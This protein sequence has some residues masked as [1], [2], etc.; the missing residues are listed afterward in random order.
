MVFSTKSRIALCTFFLFSFA[1][2][3]FLG[4]GKGKQAKTEQTEEF[5]IVATTGIIADAVENIVGDKAEVRALMG[6]GVDPHLYKAS[7]GDVSRLAEADIIVY[8]GL[9][10]EGKM[11]EILDKMS[12]RKTVIAAGE[13]LPDSLLVSPTEYA[14]QH[15]PHIWFDLSLWAK[16]VDKLGQ[17]LA[18]EKPEYK[19]EILAN[20]KEY[21]G[22]IEALHSRILLDIAGIPKRQRVLITAHDAFGYFGRA[23]EIEVRGLQGISTVSEY[24]LRDVSELVD[25][26]AD[27]EIKAIFV[28]SSVPKRS[29]EAVQKGVEGKG[30]EVAIGGELYSDALGEKGSEAE[31]YLGMVK[32][33]VNTIVQA[34]K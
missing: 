31:T 7:E 26:I 24:G 3:L 2:I 34:L 10:L 11:G 15:D 6:A 20:T 25:Y 33:N 29:I 28:E 21:A 18:K 23:Y 32:H 4:C 5:S 13:L 1:S 14:G 19:D 30:R 27:N 22:K 17:E 12:R 16:M 9:R 8:N